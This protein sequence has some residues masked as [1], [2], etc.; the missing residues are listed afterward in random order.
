MNRR[1]HRTNIFAWRGFAM[2]AEHRLRDDLHV[3]NPFLEL[4]LVV[5]F[6]SIERLFLGR[7]AR[8]ITINAQPVHLAS[9]ANQIL[10]DYR[11]VVLALARDDTRRTTNARR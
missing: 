5:S 2:L 9:A 4:L 1:V 10:A 3:V 8:V 11:H 6:K 7:I